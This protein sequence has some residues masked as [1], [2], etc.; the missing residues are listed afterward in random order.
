MI[1]M[2]SVTL[3]ST[4]RYQILRLAHIIIDFFPQIPSAQP[5]RLSYYVISVRVSIAIHVPFHYICKI[6]RNI[7]FAEVLYFPEINHGSHKICI[8]FHFQR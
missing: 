5:P 8:Y 4:L 6:E 1:N 7:Q 3:F 2:F